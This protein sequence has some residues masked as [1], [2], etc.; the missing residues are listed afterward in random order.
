MP[1][2][3][4]YRAESDM[5]IIDVR[6]SSVGQLFDNRDPAPFRERDLDP[7]LVNYL[8]DAAEDLSRHGPF[9]IVLWCADPKVEGIE[10]AFRA[11]FD[12]ELDRIWRERRRRRGV[13]LVTLVIGVLLLA[14]LQVSAQLLARIVEG[15]TAAA[16]REGLVIFSWV[17]LWRPVDTFV[18]DWIPAR[19]REAIMTRL[20]DAP[21]DVRAAP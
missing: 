21:I 16:I 14:I 4:R 12:Y 1:Q 17:V 18:Y 15:T 20:H 5:H 13:G 11:H 2:H 7:D 10:P 6:V 8:V 3:P 9:K 19:R